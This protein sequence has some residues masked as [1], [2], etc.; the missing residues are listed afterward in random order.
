[1]DTTRREF[2]AAAA[3]PI[4]LGVQDK[5]GTKPPV[6]GTGVYLRG[7]TT[8]ASC[9]RPSSG[10]TRTAWSRTRR[11]TSTCTTPCTRRATSADTVVVF[12]PNGNFVRS[13]GKEFRGVAHGLQHPRGR[14]DEVPDA[15]RRQC[16]RPTPQPEQPG[17]CRQDHAEGGD[18]LED[19]RPA[20][21]RRLQAGRGRNAPAPYNPTNVAIAPNGD[22]YVADGYGSYLH[23]PVQQQGGVHPD[24]RRPRLRPGKLREPHGIWMDTRAATPVL[25][26]ADRRNNRL[27]RFTL[28]GPAHR[29][30]PAA[31]GCRAT[32]TSARAWS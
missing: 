26:V 7:A 1:M 16:P 4:L 31:S 27:Q 25:V 15:Q 32:S 24:L 14:P 12:D 2:L 21:I 6:I 10:A 13:W 18:R 19:R 11:A 22:V 3:A 5:A 23:Q 28:D 9:R 8:G 30:R 29:L 17:G 20:A